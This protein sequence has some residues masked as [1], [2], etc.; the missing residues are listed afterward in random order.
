M[1]GLGRAYIANQKREF[2]IELIAAPIV[3]LQ[4]FGKFQSYKLNQSEQ[5]VEA[6]AV[7]LCDRKR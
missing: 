5:G 7:L 2:L 3:L 1:S 4:V 6:Q